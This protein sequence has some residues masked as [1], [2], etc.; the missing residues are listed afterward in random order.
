[1]NQ[2]QMINKSMDALFENAAS[3]A[4]LP[5]E[6]LQTQINN[7]LSNENIKESFDSVFPRFKRSCNY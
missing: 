3:L 5:D 1:M 2:R 4:E 6:E 7:A